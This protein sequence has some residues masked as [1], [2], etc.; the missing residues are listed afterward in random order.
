M[1]NCHG[2]LSTA[3]R[4]TQQQTWGEQNKKNYQ[5]SK[6]GKLHSIFILK[7]FFTQISI[8]IGVFWG[9]L[10]VRV[11]SGLRAIVIGGPEPVGMPPGRAVIG[12]PIARVASAA[13]GAG[14]GI[15]GGVPVGRG[16]AGF[17]PD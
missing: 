10:F 15:A 13:A 8:Y 7:K 9:G 16:I 14:I 3:G 5:N 6:R 17:P 4:D 2:E 11:L 12:E 1:Y